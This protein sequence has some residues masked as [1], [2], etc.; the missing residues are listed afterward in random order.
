M[1]ALS[2]TGLGALEN[3]AGNGVFRSAVMIKIDLTYEL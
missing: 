1:N 3:W 2:K